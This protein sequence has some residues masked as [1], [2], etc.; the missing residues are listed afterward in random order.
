MLVPARLRTSHARAVNE[1]GGGGK[2]EL[3]VE[4]DRGKKESKPGRRHESFFLEKIAHHLSNFTSV[5]MDE[6]RH[7]NKSAIEEVADCAVAMNA[8]IEC[9][10]LI[11][12]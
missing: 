10:A 12:K 1:R 8:P 3:R 2:W 9:P 11:Q 5:V 6:V 4:L 7:N